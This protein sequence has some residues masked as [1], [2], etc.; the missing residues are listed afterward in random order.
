MEGDPLPEE[1]T[2]ENWTHYPYLRW[3]FLN[4]RELVP[5]APIDRGTGPVLELPAEPRPVEELRLTA[6][7]GSETTVGDVLGEHAD[8][9][10][11]VHRG[12]VV[13]EHY[14][15][16][17][18]P[19]SPHL[20]QSVSKSIAGSLAGILVGEGVLDPADAVTDH[21]PELAGGAFDG[22]TVRHVL[23]MRTG[24]AYS[25][26]YLDPDS[27]V[28]I[29]E[30]LGGWR[31]LRPGRPYDSV[32][33]QI[34]GL[35]NARGHGELFDYRSILT[36]LLAWIMERATGT[37]YPELL[38]AKLWSRMGAEHSAEVTVRDGI[39][40]ADGGVCATLRDLARFGLLHLG[41]PALAPPLIPEAWLED[42]RGGA[43]YRNQWWV[44]D[45]DRFHARGIHGQLCHVDVP[46]QLVC[47][48]LATHPL[49]VDER[50]LIDTLSALAASARFLSDG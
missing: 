46:A 17:F 40:M 31:P 33:E 48:K 20:L 44:L 12:R 30:E 15:N 24:T 13:A 45:R 18:G 2:L 39:A 22:A 6:G 43:G 7:D 27:D 36:D 23:D 35:G 41:D 5:M 37:S 11:V 21:V 1:V 38:G 16:G 49:P 34:A 32:Y 28:R 47:A 50:L 14:R 8:G 3:G 42:T 9:Y 19:D 10:I 26:E 4:T 29:T 25:E